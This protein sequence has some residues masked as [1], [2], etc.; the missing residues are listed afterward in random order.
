MS[1]QAVLDFVQ[2]VRTDES[3]QA[4]LKELMAREQQATLHAMVK[5][6][7]DKGFHFTA[8]E[9]Q[10]TV[11]TE[12]ER[13]HGAGTLDDQALRQ[14][15]GGVASLTCAIN[16]TNYD[17]DRE[18]KEGFASVDERDVLGRLMGVPV[19]SWSYKD[20]PGVRHIG[21]M[22]QDFAAA[23]SV[24]ADDR[25]IHMADASGVCLAAIRALYRIVQDKDAQLQDLQ[26]K[27]DQLQK[28]KQR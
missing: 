24:G 8:E 23:F 17:S 13:Q 21:P 9:Y 10:A 19:Q 16:F 7:G 14:F 12:L 1:S 2:K 22:A 6:A 26:A 25:H 28:E 3:L 20:S 15:A 27:V 4:S 11:K 18:L 5:L